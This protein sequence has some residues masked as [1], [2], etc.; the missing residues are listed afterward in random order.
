MIIVIISQI[1]SVSTQNV[2]SRGSRLELLFLVS[3]PPLDHLTLH[4]IYFSLYIIYIIHPTHAVT[5]WVVS[6]GWSSGV[7]RP[8]TTMFAPILATNKNTDCS[9]E[10]GVNYKSSYEE[11]IY[12]FHSTN[13]LR[14]IREDHHHNLLFLRYGPA[15]APPFMGGTA[16]PVGV[17]RPKTITMYDDPR[18][19]KAWDIFGKD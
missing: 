15:R 11:S 1:V 2:F 5:P 8:K 3:W 17:T 19:I 16:V 14:Y 6:G 9:S 12:I 4:P 10:L 13:L 18:V 7:T